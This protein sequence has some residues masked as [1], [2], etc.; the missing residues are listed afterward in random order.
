M[1]EI[2]AIRQ[3]LHYLR[4]EIYSPRRAFDAFLDGVEFKKEY[5]DF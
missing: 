2:E 4:G 5:S 1:V 3:D